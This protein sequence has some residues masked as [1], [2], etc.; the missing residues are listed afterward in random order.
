M[1]ASDGK[2]LNRNH[3]FLLKILSILI[4]L[5]SL[6]LAFRPDNQIVHRPI[7]EDGY[8]AL[9]VASNIASGHGVTIDGVHKT[10]GFQPLFTFLCVPAFLLA[11][12]NQYMAIRFVLL[13][14]WLIFLLTAY[15]M[16]RIAVDSTGTKVHWQ[17]SPTFWWIFYLFVSFTLLFIVNFNGLETGFLLFLYACTWRYYQKTGITTWKQTVLFAIILG[18][19]V[20]T[21]IDAVFFVMIFT[22][23]Y[24]FSNSGTF[25]Q[26]LKRCCTLGGISFIVSSPWWIFNYINFGS[27]FPTSGKAYQSWITLG[28]LFHTSSLERFRDAYMALTRV[29]MPVVYLGQNTYEGIAV[30][31]IRT[32]LLL[33]SGWFLWHWRE[34]IKSLFKT[35]TNSDDTMRTI[36][37]MII[38]IT[39]CIVLIGSYILTFSATWFFTRYFAPLLLVSVL[40]LGLFFSSMHA[41]YRAFMRMVIII[42]IL[43]L[44]TVIILLQRGTFQSDFINNQIFLVQQH[45]PP[46][47]KVAA[48]QTGTLGFFRPHI[49]NLDGKVNPDAVTYR[50][51]LLE[52]VQQNRVEWLCDETIMLTD[53]FGEKNLLDNGWKKIDSK[54]QFA[55]FHRESGF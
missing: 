1:I 43:P 13:L 49:V 54:G 25:V 6:S 37:F 39:A 28:T 4:L 27:F 11:G 21:R 47:S 46:D 9:S 16:G 17:H 41:K 10:N 35:N 40:I 30:A 45:V 22:L 18:L 44:F 55:I 26:R 51:H 34:K 12:G 31:V 32:I 20:L 50:A 2:D 53:I 14:H 7:V 42:L 3:F 19:L 23:F 36:K 29:L 38:F 33:V 24:F 8:Y 48:F 52:Y 15:V 5:G